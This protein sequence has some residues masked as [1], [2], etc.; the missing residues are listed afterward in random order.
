M[1]RP[2]GGRYAR[3]AGLRLASFY[4]ST[5]GVGIVLL[6]SFT[7]VLLLNIDACRIL[8]GS[9]SLGLSRLQVVSSP[10]NVPLCYRQEQWKQL[11]VVYLFKNHKNSSGHNQKGILHTDFDFG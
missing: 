9:V 1:T 10:V 5:P 7:V 6:T 11:S 8:R 3:Q 2:R 4:K